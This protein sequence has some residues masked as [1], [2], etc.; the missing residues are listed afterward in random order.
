MTNY[1]FSKKYA[2]LWKILKINLIYQYFK[3][4]KITKTKRHKKQH[5]CTLK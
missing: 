1:V 4:K 2:F 5:L 3:Q